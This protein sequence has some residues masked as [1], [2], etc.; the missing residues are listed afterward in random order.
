M[1][2]DHQEGVLLL[3]RDL[4]MGVG[5]TTQICLW[6]PH[7]SLPSF[8]MG[9][10]LRFRL[11]LPLILETFSVGDNVKH[12]NHHAEW[13]KSVKGNVPLLGMGVAVS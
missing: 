7:R 2:P 8:S 4:G 12:I 6:F 1:S 10:S 9:Q 11:C 13:V 5:K 3:E